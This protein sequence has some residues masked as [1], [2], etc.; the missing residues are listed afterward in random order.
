MKNKMLLLSLL[1]L[2]YITT[3]AQ[4]HKHKTA[5]VKCKLVYDKELGRDFYENLDTTIKEDSLMDWLKFIS[6]NFKAPD[7]TYKEGQMVKFDYLIEATGKAVFVKLLNL[8]DDK[9]LEA[10]AKRLVSLLPPYTPGTCNG[11]PVASKASI[12]FPMKSKKYEH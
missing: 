5:E 11:T 4:K 9:E 3:Y 12:Q 2:M 6:V 10:E 1:M 7:K 8:T